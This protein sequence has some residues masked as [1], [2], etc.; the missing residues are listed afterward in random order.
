MSYFSTKF[1][2]YFKDYKS[3]EENNVSKVNRK[4]YY[5]DKEVVETGVQN[6]KFS[7]LKLIFTIVFIAAFFMIYTA[8]IAGWINK[9]FNANL[10][11]EYFVGARPI[12]WYASPLVFISY[13]LSYFDKSIRKSNFLR[14]LAL[15]YLAYIILVIY[16]FIYASVTGFGDFH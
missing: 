4:K 9:L 1:S 14:I 10:K 12:A 5:A 11:I 3:L 13:G 7:I 15:F 2:M 16:V 6:S 8:D